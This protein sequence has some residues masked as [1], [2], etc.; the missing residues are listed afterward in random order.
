MKMSEAL[1]C[2]QA[3]NRCSSHVVIGWAEGL[4]KL[5]SADLQKSKLVIPNIS[6]CKYFELIGSG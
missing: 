5:W 2:K 3:N 4:V 1:L 6:F